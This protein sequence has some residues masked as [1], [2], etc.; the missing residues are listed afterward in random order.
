MNATLNET[1]YHVKVR[2]Q[3]A[4]AWH[5]LTTSG[6]MNRLRIHAMELK[7][8]EDADAFTNNCRAS[9]PGFEFKVVPV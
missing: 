8:I 6:A 2:K 3:G 5:F 9:N 1:R 4:K 7:R